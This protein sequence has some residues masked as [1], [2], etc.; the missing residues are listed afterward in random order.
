MVL[1]LQPEAMMILL[2]GNHH[3]IH[4]IFFEQLA[5]CSMEGSL[6]TRSHVRVRLS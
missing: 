3:S 2:R 1:P 4:S 6:S 5:T